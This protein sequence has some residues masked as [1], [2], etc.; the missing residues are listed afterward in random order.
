MTNKML[1]NNN[2]DDDDEKYMK[3]II[4]QQKENSAIPNQ[5]SAKKPDTKKAI[6]SSKHDENI[7]KSDNEMIGEGE[8]NQEYEINEE[9]FNKLSPEEQQKMLMMIQMQQEYAQQHEM[10]GEGDQM[11]PEVNQEYL[12][13]LQHHMM[14]QNK[15]FNYERQK[16]K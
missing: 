5:S 13:A 8:D 2:E 3:E 6:N 12:N 10:E 16:P 9:E 15:M 11:P 1:E 14:N 4:E 7:D